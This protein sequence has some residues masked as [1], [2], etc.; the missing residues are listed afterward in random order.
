[1]SSRSV[2]LSPEPRS[3]AYQLGRWFTA[4]R[5]EGLLA[6]LTPAAWHT[7][8]ALLSFTSRDGRRV[9]TVDQLA[10]AIGQP[11]AQARARLEELAQVPWQGQLLVTPQYDASGE[12]VGAELAPLEL[13]AGAKAPLPPE[14]AAVE[15]L[16]VPQLPPSNDLKALLER[17]GINTEQTVWLL[18]RFPAERIRRQLEWLPARQAR[19]PAALLIRAIEGD[20]GAPREA[21]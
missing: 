3:E 6:L 15:L 19:N 11:S 13:L 1:M 21:A 17:V 14:K 4:A 8:S 16:S 2:S 12:V 18:Q 20:W 10:V 7:L 9:F 5:R